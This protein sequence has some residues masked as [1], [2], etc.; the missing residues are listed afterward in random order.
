MSELLI[1]TYLQDL[2]EN[3]YPAEIV[4]DFEYSGSKHLGMQLNNA[5]WDIDSGNMLKLG[6][7]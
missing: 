4:T 3:G 5:V 6:K 7:D 1:E 2:H